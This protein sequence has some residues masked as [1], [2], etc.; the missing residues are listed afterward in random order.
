VL[1]TVLNVN[2]KALEQGAGGGIRT[3]VRR[4]I[5]VLCSYDTTTKDSLRT[6]SPSGGLQ[7]RHQAT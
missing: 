3:V 5:T 6:C 1:N 4:E 2:P 7:S